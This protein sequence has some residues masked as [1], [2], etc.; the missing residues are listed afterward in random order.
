MNE[1][2][3]THFTLIP[4]HT[5]F[6]TSNTALQSP[7]VIGQPIS[8]SSPST[9]V[10]SGGIK[11]QTQFDHAQTDVKR[12]RKGITCAFVTLSVDSINQ[13]ARAS[14][15]QSYLDL[16][17]QPW[18]LHPFHPSHLWKGSVLLPKKILYFNT[19]I[20]PVNCVSSFV[21]GIWAAH[22]ASF[23]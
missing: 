9:T 23:I 3:F 7:H 6:L 1:P 13:D 17:Q 4:G 11:R 10:C 19:K 14:F 2:T 22:M 8:T 12:K 21:K 18:Q 5:N 15:R 20:C 16:L